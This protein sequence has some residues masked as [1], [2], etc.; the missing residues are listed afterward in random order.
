MNYLKLTWALIISAIIIRLIFIIFFREYIEILSDGDGD[1]IIEDT[2]CQLAIE[3][4]KVNWIFP[5][6]KWL[7]TV[8]YYEFGFIH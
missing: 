8:I 2:N 5:C 1:I 7:L 4:S 3:E 6:I